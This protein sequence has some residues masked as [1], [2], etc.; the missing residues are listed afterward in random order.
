[1]PT[2]TVT[3]TES[4][5]LDG[6]SRG[7]EKS[8]T[9]ASIE[10][11]HES[12]RVLTTSVQKIITMVDS[13]D[14]SALALDVQLVKYIRLTNLDDTDIISLGIIQTVETAGSV[15]I[16]LLPGESFVAGPPEDLIKIA[17]SADPGHASFL[18]LQTIE[19][20]ALTNSAKLEIFVA[21]V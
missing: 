19:A 11:V 2:L 4:I 21:M 17:A 6:R 14:D 10:S 1:M 7:V 13:P 15:C 3:H 12:S 5:T 20:K 18:D 16:K 8:Y 9:I